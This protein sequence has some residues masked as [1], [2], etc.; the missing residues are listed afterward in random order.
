MVSFRRCLTTWTEAKNAAAISSS[1]IPRSS[2]NV[3]NARNWS[4]GCS[5]AR[6]TF[7]ASA[8]SSAVVARGF[9]LCRSAV[10]G[11]HDTGLGWC[12]GQALRVDEA[13]QVLEAP[14]ARRYLE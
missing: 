6:W 1:D 9:L 4:S 10:V 8:S 14:P 5:G 12:V 11:L 3:R 2:R 7:S 13:L